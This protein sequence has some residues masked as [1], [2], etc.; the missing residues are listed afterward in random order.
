MVLHGTLPEVL[1]GL[2]MIHPE[3]KRMLLLFTLCK[4][5]EGRVNMVL[6]LNIKYE[7]PVSAIQ[8]FYR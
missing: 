8:L 2:G 7:L 4:R 3:D 5:W 6:K 1:A